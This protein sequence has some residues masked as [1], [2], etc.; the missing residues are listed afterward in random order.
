MVFDDDEEEEE[1]ERADHQ[2]QNWTVQLNS[3]ADVDGCLPPT[4]CC[5]SIWN[6]F[7][8]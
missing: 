3:Q 1:M 6:L 2:T 4:K 7:K 5:V 8:L